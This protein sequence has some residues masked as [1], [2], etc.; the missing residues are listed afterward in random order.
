MKKVLVVDDEKSIRLTFT[1]FLEREGFETKAHQ[2]VSDALEC[3]GEFSPDVVVTDIIMP[4]YSG[5]ELLKEIQKIA[6][7]IPVIIMTGEPSLDTAT[8]SVRLKAFDYLQKPVNKTELI[9]VVNQAY[10]FKKISDEKKELEKENR[11][12]KQNLEKLIVDRTGALKQAMHATISTILEMIDF[13]DPYCV[14]HNRKTGNLA[15]DIAARMELP[16][17]SRNTL[18]IAGYLH[19]IGKVA[20]PSEILSKSRKLKPIEYEIVKSHVQVGFDILSKVDL[21]LPIAEIVYSHHERLD[22]SGYPKGIGADD[23]CT[24]ARVLM[25]ADVVEAMLNHRPY[26]PAHEIDTVIDELRKK[27]GTVFDGGI[28]DIVEKM[29]LENGYELRGDETEIDFSI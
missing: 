12:H 29:F 11:E 3:I 13:K 15:Y 16:E 1:K 27:N 24:E 9:R 19:D 20:I 18:L 25:I 2:N 17:N 10:K 26:R 22:G 6:P 5:I 23:I 14:G 28:T 7:D 8:D 4:R 21:S